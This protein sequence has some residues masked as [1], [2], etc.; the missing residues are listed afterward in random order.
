MRFISAQI[1]FLEFDYNS[2]YEIHYFHTTLFFVTLR[3]TYCVVEDLLHT[4]LKASW[5]EKKIT[6]NTL[7]ILK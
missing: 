4:S 6:Q 7:E 5:N 2:L 3:I 1:R